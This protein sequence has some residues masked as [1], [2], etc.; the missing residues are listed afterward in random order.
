MPAVYCAS[1]SKHWPW[2][3]AL[4]AAGLDIRASWISWSHNMD[5]SEPTADEWASHWQRCVQEASAAD[6]VLVYAR[7][8]ERQ[9]G[10]LIEMGAGLAAGAQVFLVSDSPWS[11]A[12]HPR[13]RTFP[14]LADAVAAIC[15]AADGERQRRVRAA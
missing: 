2:W 11:V 5:D 12:N 9:N 6:V 14:S 4:R 7:S 13:V 10:A 1:K 8:D 15:A 3:Q